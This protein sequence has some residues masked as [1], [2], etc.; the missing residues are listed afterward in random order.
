VFFEEPAAD[1]LVEAILK[2][3]TVEHRFSPYFIR[4]H[5]EQFDEQH[6]LKKMGAFVAEKLE[7]YRETRKPQR[8]QVSAAAGDREV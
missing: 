2:F 3:E 4:E 5:A 6:F 7:D 1:A 8:V